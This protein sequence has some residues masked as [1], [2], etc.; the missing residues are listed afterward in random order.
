MLGIRLFKMLIFGLSDRNS[1]LLEA[2]KNSP[3]FCFKVPVQPTY[4]KDFLS[5][6]Y[7]ECYME[8]DVG[9]SLY[10]HHVFHC[11]GQVIPCR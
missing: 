2:L 8:V 7:P 1:S 9:C 3:Y 11:I 5:L 6:G 10:M 4:I